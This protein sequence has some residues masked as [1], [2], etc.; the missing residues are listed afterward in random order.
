ML[1]V[2]FSVKKICFLEHVEAILDFYGSLC[3]HK[4]ILKI[5]SSHFIYYADLYD[6]RQIGTTSIAFES[7]FINRIL[8]N[9]HSEADM[10]YILESYF[11]LLPR[12]Q[13]TTWYGKISRMICKQHKR[14]Y[15]AYQKI[16]LIIM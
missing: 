15:N 12:V 2:V 16:I 10:M 5:H 1:F 9:S 4:I 3:K 13:Y 8:R 14:G 6:F 7:F 11:P